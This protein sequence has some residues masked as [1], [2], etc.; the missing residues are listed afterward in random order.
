MP[1]KLDSNLQHNK[2]HSR[3][4]LKSGKFSIKQQA[5]LT[6]NPHKKQIKREQKR[7]IVPPPEEVTPLPA[8]IQVIEV[9][10]S[11]AELLYPALRSL[12][13]PPQSSVHIT[14]VSSSAIEL[15]QALSPAQVPASYVQQLF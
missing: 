11:S 13:I 8:T 9:Q 4:L 14:K 10:L 12:N 6:L 1:F 15:F 7:L 3:G 2:L 5:Q